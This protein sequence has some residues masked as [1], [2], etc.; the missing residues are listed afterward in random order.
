MHEEFDL[1][2]ENEYL[3]NAVKK[4]HLNRQSNS[5]SKLAHEK[6]SILMEE[7][8]IIDNFFE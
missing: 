5:Y 7:S 2:F 1:P 6:S 3:A 4:K 8:T